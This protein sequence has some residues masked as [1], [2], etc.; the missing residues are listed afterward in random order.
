MISSKIK[1]NTWCCDE[2]GSPEGNL[3]LTTQAKI[4]FD[5]LKEAIIHFAMISIVGQGGKG[6]GDNKCDGN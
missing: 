5:C 6:W 3:N 1:V 2:P 4:E